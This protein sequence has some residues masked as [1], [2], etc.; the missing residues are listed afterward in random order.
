MKLAQIFV[1]IFLPLFCVNRCIAETIELRIPPLAIQKKLIEGRA[2]ELVLP[3]FEVFNSKGEGVFWL[4][5]ATASARFKEQ[6]TNIVNSP[7]KNQRE[8]KFVLADA[9]PQTGNF[10]L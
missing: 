6:L 7:I 9:A 8:I 1:L 3:E 4:K 10:F 2:R 5:N